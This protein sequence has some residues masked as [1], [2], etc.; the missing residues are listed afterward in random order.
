MFEPKLTDSHPESARTYPQKVMCKQRKCEADVVVANWP[1][2]EEGW[3]DW[4]FIDCSLLP[5]GA[6][7]W[8]GQL[9]AGA[10]RPRRTRSRTLTEEGRSRAERVCA[11]KSH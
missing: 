5:A 10:Y 6:V 8:N 3:T 4:R 2:S 1:F 11:G 9:V 7:N